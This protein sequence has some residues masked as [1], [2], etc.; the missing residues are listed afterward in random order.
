MKRVADRASFRGRMGL[1]LPDRTVRW[2]ESGGMH[3]DSLLPQLQLTMMS[4]PKPAM[5]IIQL[6]LVAMI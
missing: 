1:E 4:A 3:W 5:L 2:L 6:E